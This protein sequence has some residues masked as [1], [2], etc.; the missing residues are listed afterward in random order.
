MPCFG[1][2]FSARYMLFTDNYMCLSWW[3][4]VSVGFIDVFVD[5]AA[6]GFMGY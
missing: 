5:R 4:L 2:W 6:D 3:S 1:R